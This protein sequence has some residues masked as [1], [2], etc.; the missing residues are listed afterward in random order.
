MKLTVIRLRDG[1]IRLVDSDSHKGVTLTVAAAQRLA[2]LLSR[3]AFG[4][5]PG[6]YA[7]VD[8]E[9]HTEPRP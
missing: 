4:P 2:G 7:S 1:V 6:N 5:N 9:R 3:A 8:C